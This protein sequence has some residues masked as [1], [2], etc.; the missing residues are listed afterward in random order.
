[1]GCT[2][3]CETTNYSN[4]YIYNEYQKESKKIEDPEVF[5]DFK[6]KGLPEI[7]NNADEKEDKS[8]KKNYGALASSLQ[9]KIKTNLPSLKNIMKPKKKCL[10]CGKFVCSGY[11]VLY[12]QIQPELI[13]KRLAFNKIKEKSYVK[14]KNKLHLWIF[15]ELL[16]ND[17]KKKEDKHFNEKNCKALV[18][19]LP[20]RAQTNLPSLK[21]IMQ[22][23][24]KDLSEKEKLFVVFLWECDNIDY[25][26]ESYI[27]GGDVD[28]TPEGV[29][30]NGKTVCSGYARL[31]KD[32]ASYLGLNVLSIK[33]YI[34]GFRY[35]P[36]KKA[37]KDHEYNV[38]NID[39][40]WHAI[41]CTRGAGYIEG[42]KYIKEFNEFYFLTNPE[43]LIKSHF[44]KD[45]KWQLTKKR[46]TLDDFE[47]WPVVQSSFYKYGFTKFFPEEAVLNLKDSNT[48]KFIVWG[49]NIKNKDVLCRVFF[50]Q[51][52]TYFN[53][54]CLSFVIPF[55]NKFEINC[56]FNKKGTYLIEIFGR[57]NE[58]SHYKIM[59]VYL[60]NAEN[61]AKKELK[62]PHTYSESNSIKLI[63]PLY[64]GLK[65]GKTVKFKMESDLDI[66]IID[67]VIR[68]YLERNDKGFFE[69]EIEIQSKPGKSV[70]IG[71]LNGFFS[72]SFLIEYDVV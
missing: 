15:P 34:K 41:D 29:F 66:I 9:M 64:N 56:S 37:K 40:N 45:E 8:N 3:S 53:Q 19:S 5:Y 12:N 25:D 65:S 62:F 11:V 21:N 72:T 35:Q 1:M 44:P 39:G 24:T 52:N 23:K 20:K 18:S 50:L 48:L 69:T 60:V 30:R 46:Y 26:A 27:S 49:D 14:E 67:D 7:I 68:H 16:K 63:I 2:C 55:K 51:D 38:V 28:C 61:D 58:E 10:K 33:G 36:E 71:K 59:I 32:I 6:K 4:P 54:P 70:K 17:V 31:F 57:N 22:S 47:R 13:I 43:F 42:K